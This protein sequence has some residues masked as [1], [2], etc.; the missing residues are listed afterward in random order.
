MASLREV[1]ELF[2][3][4]LEVEAGAREAALRDWTAGREELR[5]EVMELLDSHEEAGSFL[6]AG[7]GVT[8]QGRQL[9]RWKLGE[10]IGM[11][12]MGDVY[13]AERADGQFEMSVAVKVLGAGVMTEE[14]RKRFL[15]ERQILARLDHAGIARLLD[16]GITEE[17]EPSL[18]MEYVAGTGLGEALQGMGRKARLE[19]FLGIAR[20]VEYAHQQLVVHADLKPSNILVRADGTPKLLDFGIAWVDREDFVGGA[21]GWTPTYASPE[22]K[23]GE[24]PTVAS[25]V[26]GLGLLLREIAG[27]HAG[28]A[29]LVA[30]IECATAEE[31][32]RRYASVERLAGEIENVLAH[33]PV[34]VRSSS[35]AYVVG[36]FAQRHWFALGCGLAILGFAGYAVQQRRVAEEHFLELRRAARIM[37]FDVYEGIQ[38][39]NPPKDVMERI[40]E[41]S[42]EVLAAL[43]KAKQGEPGLLFDIASAEERLAELLIL[44]GG[45]SARA[46]AL[47]RSSLET[48]EGLLEKNETKGSYHRLAA[49]ALQYV[50]RRQSGKQ[51]A[52]ATLDRMERH[53][54]RAIEL[55]EP[56]SRDWTYLSVIDLHRGEL[57]GEQGLRAAIARIEKRGKEGP[58]EDSRHSQLALEARLK[59]AATKPADWRAV[60]AGYER[61]AGVLRSAG[62]MAAMVEMKHGLELARLD[63]ERRGERLANALEA[64]RLIETTQG[65]S[66]AYH[67]LRGDLEAAA[68]DGASARRSYERAL[69][70]NQWH[71]EALARVFEM[72]R[73]GFAKVAKEA[74]C[75]E[76][77]ELQGMARRLR[78]EKELPDGPEF[79]ACLGGKN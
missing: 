30:V 56:K 7:R 4:L 39:L 47:L 52:L 15:A 6:E 64:A 11:G 53:V 73:A 24:R 25:D 37:V 78:R 74:Q 77:R 33:K 49:S 51:E 9:G 28:E 35:I 72:R 16:G 62:R 48:V 67:V 29:D 57:E 17:G 5:A 54:K 42:T 70:V 43:G 38:Y 26:Y 76:Y 46:D 79:K 2:G 8:M 68:G 31:V 40:V 18:V 14:G 22:Q 60:L 21:V 45:D 65:A 13:R 23:R 32:G 66:P 1:E 69:G 34:V 58:L 36:R 50:A 71:A 59:L 27:P 10:L 41:S 61:E 75:G 20:A 12:G 44:S 63:A 19:L 55:P 3:R